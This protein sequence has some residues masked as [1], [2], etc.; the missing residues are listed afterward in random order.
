MPG[1]MEIG[2]CSHSHDISQHKG[3]GS[4]KVWLK[5]CRPRRIVRPATE[6]FIPQCVDISACQLDQNYWGVRRFRL[7][8]GVRC[9]KDQTHL[10]TTRKGKAGGK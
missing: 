4:L 5:C 1:V 2:S 6:S 10:S 8:L 9:P 3:Y 7:N